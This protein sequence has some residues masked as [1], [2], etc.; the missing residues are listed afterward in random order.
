MTAHDPRYGAGSLGLAFAGGAAALAVV[1]ALAGLSIVEFGLYD[2]AATRAHGAFASWAVHDTFIHATQR[3]A[4]GA[5]AP[6]RFSAAQTQSGLQLYGAHCAVCHGGPATPRAAWV[7]GINPSPPFLLDSATRWSPAE[8]YVIVSNGVK[9]TAMP[10]WRFTLTDV[11]RWD[12][13]AFLES[14]PR[15]PPSAPWRAA[16][17][18]GAP[19]RGAGP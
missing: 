11:E 16:L 17:G 7:S 18:A 1:I 10:A 14:L 8:L 3:A 2:P 9:M 19:S 5:P 6:K 4:R 12:L 13:V 15:S